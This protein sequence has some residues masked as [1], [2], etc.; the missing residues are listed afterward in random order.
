MEI[1]ESVPPSVAATCFVSGNETVYG[2]SDADLIT[3]DIKFFRA[4]S[5]WE[6]RS[7]FHGAWTII[8]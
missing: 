3:S 4:T 2:H 5:G 7:D 8:F 6:N 1:D